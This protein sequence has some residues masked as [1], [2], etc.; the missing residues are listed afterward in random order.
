[1]NRVVSDTVSGAWVKALRMAYEATGAEINGLVV[2]VRP[3]ADGEIAEVDSI[4]GAADRELAARRLRSVETV[5]STIFPASLW[6]SRHPRQ[7]LFDR[8][9]R[10]L[11]RV[12]RHRANSR[13]TYFERLIRYQ[14]RGA[15]DSINQLAFMI[16]AFRRGIHRRS[17]LQA[18]IFDP[19]RD[20]VAAPRCGFPCLQ[21]IG[22]PRDGGLLGVDA[23][24]VVQDLLKKGYGNYLGLARLGRFMA[25]EMGLRLGH[26]RVHVSVATLGATKASCRGLARLDPGDSGEEASDGTA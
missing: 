26:V 19:T 2:V 17:M 5:A 20:H 14:P 15:P 22:F 24:Y 10:I 9:E 23:T 12:K 6:D 18:S 4:R 7:R 16:D 13:G 1:M 8:Y 11:P 21:H 25:T 3:S